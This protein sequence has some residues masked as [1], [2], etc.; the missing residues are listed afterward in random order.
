M[1][2][3]QSP[4]ILFI[5]LSFGVVAASTEWD[6]GHTGQPYT[7]VE[8]TVTEG[9]W[10]SVDISPD[11]KTLIFDLLGDIYRMPVSGGDATLVHGGPA[12]ERL[13]SFSPDGSKI[14]FL[15]DASG[16]DN[17]WISDV[18]GSGRKQVTWETVDKI[19]GPAWGPSGEYIVASKAYATVRHTYSSE[20]RL[21]HL[22]GKKGRLI[23]QTPAN[24]K[25]VQEAQLSGHYLY[26]SQRVADTG[27]YVDA[28]HLNH[29]VM[30]KDMRDGTTSEFLKGFGGASTP[31]V[32]HDSKR[33]A[34]VRRVK[35]KTVLFV[36]DTKTGKQKP[37]YDG[38][39][40]DLRADFYQQGT[41]YPKFGWFPDNRHIVIWGKGKL[42]RV[43]T[44]TGVSEQIPFRVTSRHRITSTPRFE[45]EL[46][47][48]RFTVR[49]IPN[50]ALSPNGK[51]VVFEGIGH[52]WQ[53]Q[54]A[55]GV[56]QRLTKTEA[57]EAEPAYSFDGR[58]IAYVEWDDEKGGKLKLM[59][60]KG[61]NIKTL[62]QSRGV[63]RQPSFSQDG[64]QLVYRLQSNNKSLGGYR[65]KAGIYRIPVSGGKPQYVTKEAAVPQ[66]SPD[67]Q[68]IYYVKGSSAEGWF[69]NK[70]ES[71]NLQGF[72][73]REHAKAVG[74][75]RPELIVSP[76][77]RWL[78]FKEYQ[79]YYV[80]PYRE[81]GTPLIVKSESGAVPVAR[82]TDHG[83]YDIAWSADSKT[84]YWVLGETYHSTSVSEHFSS[85]AAKR[86]S[87]IS[88]GL[89]VEGD[90]PEGSLAFVNARIITMR[91]DEVIEKGTVLVEGNR[92]AAVGASSDIVVPD[93]AKVINVD[94]RIVMPGLVDM[95]GHIECC[96]EGGLIPQKQAGFYAAMAFGV[97][98]NYDPYTSEFPAYVG[99]ELQKAGVA[100][101]PRFI[102][103]G[104]VIYGRK[105]KADSA[106][107]PINNMDD[108]RRIMARKQ[109]LGGTIIKSYKQPMRS[110][111][112]QL[113]KAGR[114]AG[115]MVDVEGESHFY[116]NL[117][118]LLDGHACL[119]HNLPVANYYDDLISL[120]AHGDTANTPTLIV[121]FGEIM[122]EN[123]LYQTTRAWEQSKIRTYVQNTISGYG[124]LLRAHSAPPY[125]RGMTALH[126][127]DEIYEVGFRSVARSVKR[128][129]DAGVL[130]NAGSHGQIAG[131]AMHWEMQLMSQGGMENH[132]VLKTATLNGAKTLKLDKQIGSLEV[133]KLADLIVL[134]EDPLEDIRNTN[135]VRYTMMNGRLYD[136][137]SMNEIGNYDRPRT[138]FYWE[139][140]DYKGIDWNEAWS[141]E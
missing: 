2:I 43:D 87:T 75:D 114:E 59:S 88:L 4:A 132:R 39:D 81:A 22:D 137:L 31:Q 128:L 49:A 37:V 125:V 84:L 64:K 18:D 78:A 5:L 47:P 117:G 129:D 111:R 136:S 101:G 90:V 139:L 135:S 67:S 121:T 36:Y 29:A 133:G 119:E 19:M 116:N 74:H 91:G 1:L 57:F 95:H 10:M 65:A 62:V 108:A 120:F 99:T 69:M 113:V 124:P 60:H 23:V 100:V 140:E 61:R 25:D 46:A 53:K 94:N 112:Q 8:F 102:T 93:N 79:Q 33:I 72:D 7:D 44:N 16:G 104:R 42:Y 9:T 130:I 20:I 92:I 58:Y 56:P 89:E 103:T 105:G 73:R 122:G 15:S 48:E 70:L 40:R 63:I 85:G 3:R 106:Y 80:M 45:Y 55:N 83:G 110:Q 11:G 123:Y 138:R 13:P 14:L 28:N 98:T 126:A 6:I 24:N 109:A 82:L 50:L 76:D 35:D 77:L 68:R 52:L 66:F 17:A 131:L 34:F 141:G 86:D 115:I 71:V 21:F 118:M 107:D 27:I 38:L 97:T 54:L 32:S 127:A 41:Y 96:Y 134:D 26:Y 30:R 51:D 12:I